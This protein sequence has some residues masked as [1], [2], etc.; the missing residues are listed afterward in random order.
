MPSAGTP[1]L[2]IAGLHTYFDTS[3]GVV[4]SVRGIDLAIGRAETLAVVGESGSGKSV[5]ALSILRLVPGPSGRIAAGSIF[6]EG[7]DLARLP[8]EEMR[9]IRGNGIAMIFQEPMTALNPVIRIGDQIAEVIR[10][11][12]G[13]SSKEALAE[14]E[15]LLRKV[16][17]SDPRRRLSQYP[18]ELSGGMRQRVMIAMALSCGPK[19]VVADEPTTALD[20]T[21]QAQILELMQSLKEDFGAAILLITHD[22]GVVAETAERV[23]VMYAGQIVEHADVGTLFDDPLHPYTIGLMATIPDLDRDVED[24]MLP[25]IPGTVPSLAHLPAGCAF[26]ERCPRAHERCRAEEP[27]LVAMG[28]GHEVRCWLHV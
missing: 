8:E 26:Q 23:A 7:R 15:S 12:R 18:H 27:P 2:E 5:T 14:V 9:K 19:L 17:I 11:H 21:I 13:L 20:V 3:E 16:G 24:R 4:K 1:V 6:F 22:L 10:L 28:G 25:A